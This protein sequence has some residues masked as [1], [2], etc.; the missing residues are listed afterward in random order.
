MPDDIRKPRAA[1]TKK[2]VSG[3][4]AT[5]TDVDG[6]GGVELA[7][8]DLSS[9]PLPSHEGGYKSTVSLTPACAVATFVFIDCGCHG[10][11]C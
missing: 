8:Q 9:R 6:D 7:D 2:N 11:Q 5:K 3:A 1:M 4:A 10:E